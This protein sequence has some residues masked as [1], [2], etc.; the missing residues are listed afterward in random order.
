M[1]Y[2]NVN[3]DDVPIEVIEPVYIVT[4]LPA[5]IIVEDEYE[6]PPRYGFT[7]DEVYLL[8]QLLCGDKERDGDGEYDIDYQKDTNYYEVSKVLN[9]VMNRVESCHFPNTVTEV[10][11]QERQFVVMPCNANK[12]PSEKALKI[13]QDW[14]DAY[15]ES[16]LWTQSI[17]PTHLFYHG[18]GETNITREAF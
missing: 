15:D 2:I 8:A 17:P 5:P 9:V 3:F 6:V 13:V 10:V 16:N 11:M 7:E 14:C 4:Y 18:D 1:V 12:I